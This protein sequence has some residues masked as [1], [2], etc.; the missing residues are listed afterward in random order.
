MSDSYRSFL[1]IEKNQKIKAW[2]AQFGLA[3]RWL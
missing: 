2:K 1:L 3:A